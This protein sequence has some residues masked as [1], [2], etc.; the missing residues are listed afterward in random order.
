MVPGKILIVEDEDE[1]REILTLHL[2]RTGYQVLEAENGQRA[3]EILQ[4]GNNLT[5]V[6]VII[7]DIR[8]P[9]VNGLEIIDYFKEYA[10][11]ISVIVVTGFP[12]NKLSDQLI[13]KGVKR[14]LVKPVE[15]QTLLQTVA[16][17]IA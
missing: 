12:D 14:F 11:D 3:K 15:K 7:T 13:E 4:E 9:K 10:P 17:L 1:N 2:E 5:T 16:E 6:D 8:M